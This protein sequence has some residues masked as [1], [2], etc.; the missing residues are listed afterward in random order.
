METSKRLTIINDLLVRGV[1]QEIISDDDIKSIL[2][3]KT[4]RIK[5]G[6]DPTGENIHLG[7]AI[8]IMVLRDLQR[9][10]HKIVVVIGNFTAEIGDTSDK[11]SERPTIDPK[12]VELNMKTYISQISKLLDLEKTEFNFN[13]DW[14]DKMAFD[15]FVQLT[16]L[17][18]LAEFSSRSNVAQR[19]QDG[20]RVSVR[21]MIYPIMQGYDSLALDAAIEIGGTDQRFNMLAGRIIQKAHGKKP[22]AII[23]TTLIN[24]LDGRKMSSSWG[25]TIN[26][27][28]EPKNMFGK[29]MSMR[30]EMIV[31]YFIHLTREPIHLI[32]SHRADMD[33]GKRNPRDVKFELAEKIVGMI[34]GA[35]ASNIAADTF[36]SVFQER[37]APDSIPSLTV[38][39]LNIVTILC[40]AK[41][42]KSK[43]EARRVIN[44]GGVKVNNIRIDNTE[45]VAP[46]NSVIKKGKLHH[47]KVSV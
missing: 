29:I 28:D 7:R 39:S 18:S 10:G 11:E 25:N 35:E 32:N 15:K 4:L 19:L 37:N 43:S 44:Q 31:P 9:I 42:V 1:V 26:L 30:D 45:F 14:W 17:F 38:S 46:N 36:R 6:T 41:L 23:M 8:P 2:L 16:D 40:E 21:E 12:T 34:H 24:G 13:K 5:W 20:K 47:V 27:T 22:Q 3:E 33:S